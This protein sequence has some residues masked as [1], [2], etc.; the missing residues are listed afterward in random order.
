M[1]GC[2]LAALAH[3]I[4]NAEYYGPSIFLLGIELVMVLV[5]KKPS[6]LTSL[7]ECGLT[8]IVLYAVLVK[9]VPCLEQN[10]TPNSNYPIGPRIS[11]SLISQGL[12]SLGA[13]LERPIVCSFLTYCRYYLSSLSLPIILNYLTPSQNLVHERTTRENTRR[14]NESS[15]V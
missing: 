3:I 14:Y 2:L 12:F 8:D 15:S 4:S 11:S 7:Q 10:D 9:D 1:H 6:L 13:L 5:F